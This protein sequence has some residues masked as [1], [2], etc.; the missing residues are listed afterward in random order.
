[1]RMV[2]IFSNL[3]R[4][5]KKPLRYPSLRKIGDQG[6]RSTT[7]RNHGSIDGCIVAMIATDV[8]AWTNADRTLGRVKSAGRLRRLRMRNAIAAQKF[9][10]THHRTEPP[11]EI[12]DNETAEL[13]VGQRKIAKD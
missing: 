8:D 1:M 6:L 9:P 12:G 5:S 11:F 10:G 3:T 2:D 13:L 4:F 7:T